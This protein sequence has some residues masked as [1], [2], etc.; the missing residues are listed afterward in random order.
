MLS[1]EFVV[2]QL[3]IMEVNNAIAAAQSRMDWATSSSVNASSRFPGEY[4]NARTSLIEATNYR[5]AEN[6]DAALL[7]ALRV[8][9]AL[10]YVTDAPAQPTP[11]TGPYPLPALYT[12]QTWAL[13]RD[14][15]WNIAGRPWV[16]NDPTQW[17]LLYTANRANMPEPDNPDLIH[18]G[19]VLTI[20]SIRGEV[21]EGMWVADRSY[22]LLR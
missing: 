21:R 22:V 8:I 20:P 10:A 5:D 13:A 12:V 17:T 18:P 16:Y 9:D 15:L 2:L 3:K 19:M 7:A 1:D 6:W 11:S 4:N 14:C